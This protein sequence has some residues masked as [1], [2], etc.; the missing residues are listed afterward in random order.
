[1]GCNDAGKDREGRNNMLAEALNGRGPVSLN[2]RKRNPKEEDASGNEEDVSVKK[3]R[4]ATEQVC[5]DS[6][7]VVRQQQQEW[8]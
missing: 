6:E 5:L 7:E 3:A 1:M 8:N 4:S 2:S